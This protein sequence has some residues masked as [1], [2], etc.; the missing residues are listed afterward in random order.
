MGKKSIALSTCLL[1]IFVV[2]SGC[3][4]GILESEYKKGVIAVEFKP[5]VT[6]ENATLVVLS[7]NCTV[8]Q[9]VN[10]T[11]MINGVEQIEIAMIVKVP[12][13]REQEYATLFKGNDTVSNAYVLIR[14]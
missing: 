7:Y 3:L 8:N 13:G 5:G 14:K 11:V 4:G 9:T 12:E 1:T 6:Y 2:F 10:T